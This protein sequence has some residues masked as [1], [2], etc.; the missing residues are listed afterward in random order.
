M[1]IFPLNASN[2]QS[3]TVLSD[4]PTI[5]IIR[6]SK[7]QSILFS[8]MM[9]AYSYIVIS[10]ILLISFSFSDMSL[11]ALLINSSIPIVW[12]TM[13][14]LIPLYRKKSISKLIIDA[15]YPTYGYKVTTSYRLLPEVIEW[16][17]TNYIKYSHVGEYANYIHILRKRDVVA[18]KIRWI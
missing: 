14:I 5:T 15:F 13:F 4:K 9:L 10:S 3:Q 11:F 2:P 16:L 17:D 18:I 1:G 8:V 6:V 7:W 12:T